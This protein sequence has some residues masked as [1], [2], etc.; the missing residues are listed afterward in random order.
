M[1]ITQ[2]ASVCLQCPDGTAGDG[3]ECRGT[4]QFFLFRD[5]LVKHTVLLPEDVHFPW[6]KRSM[7]F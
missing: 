5:N 4:E 6:G 1:N 3:R 7:P 2:E